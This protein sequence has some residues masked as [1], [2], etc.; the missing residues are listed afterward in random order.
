V[1]LA[2]LAA[3][4]FAAQDRFTLRVPGGLAFSDFRGYEDWQTIAVSHNGGQARNDPGQSRIAR[5]DSV[6]AMDCGTVVNPNTVQAQQREDIPI[7]QTS[8]VAGEN[9]SRIESRGAFTARPRISGVLLRWIGF[10]SEQRLVDE[11][12]TAIQPS[13]VQIQPYWNVP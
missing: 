3:A 9:R 4:S 7:P 10:A 13:N 8:S 12:V 2:I 5:A 11:Q 6:C 1:W